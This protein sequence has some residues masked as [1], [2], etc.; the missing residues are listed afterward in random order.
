MREYPKYYMKAST[1][2]LETLAEKMRCMKFTEGEKMSTLQEERKHLARE[3]ICHR[4]GNF[5]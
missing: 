5:P 2:S 4:E 3:V 1:T